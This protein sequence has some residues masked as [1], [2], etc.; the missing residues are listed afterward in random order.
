MWL[1]LLTIFRALTDPIG[2]I[3]PVDESAAMA[4]LLAGPASA[5]EDSLDYAIFNAPRV[6]H[7]G[8]PLRII[9]TT[10]GSA[11][12]PSRLDLH[13]FAG[14]TRVDGAKWRHEGIPFG[15][16]LTVP[17]SE[18][19]PGRLRAVMTRDGVPV[20]C[21]EVTVSPRPRKAGRL[22]AG[23]DPAWRSR[24]KWERDTEN[25][26]SVWIAYMFDAPLTAELSWRR[27]ADVIKDRD[28]NLLH[29]YLGLDEDAKGLGLTPDCADFPYTLR[30][31]FAWKLGLPMAMRLCRR[32]N[33]RRA[34]T[35]SASFE[36]NHDPA[37]ESDPAG[38][39]RQFFRRLKAVVHSSSLRTPPGA[40]DSDLYPVALTHASL[41]PGTV[42]ADPYGHTMVI[43]RWYPQTETQPGALMTVDAQPD[44]TVGRRLFWRGNF[45]FPA[46]DSVPGAGWKRFRPVR[47]EGGEHVVWT[48]SRIARATEDYG[49]VSDVQWRHGREAFYEAMD[50]LI[51]PSPMPL[52]IALES[53]VGALEQQVL[54]RVESIETAEAWHASKQG[55]V[56]PMPKG[57]KIFL[58]SG[59]WEDLSTPSRDM[60]LLIAM[61]VVRAFPDRVRSRP[62]RFAGKVDPDVARALLAESLSSR[63]FSYRRSDG[64]TQRLTLADLLERIEALEM[65]WNPNDCPELRWGAP[66]GSDELARC[67]RRAPAGQRAEMEAEMRPWFAARERPLQH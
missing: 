20:A 51:N 12:D 48:D 28:R 18:V 57:P 8:A 31:Y 11:E 13:L 17:S 26:F 39:F 45:L 2:P 33:A 23:K 64:S 38:A 3:G 14:Q 43:S 54:R 35:C 19:V 15:A 36:T 24:I 56:I 44:E 41:R 42:Y 66:E 67:A 63:A 9:A 59:P 6:P 30:A 62:E 58:T 65:G 40:D 46:D 16:V 60:R 29:G 10:T 7:V 5:C 37:R 52:P 47:L 4:A 34:P 53:V 32:G 50:A 61:D 55:K 25:F 22:K 27:L 21:Q 1:L 49:D